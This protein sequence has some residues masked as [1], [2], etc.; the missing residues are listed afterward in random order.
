MFDIGSEVRIIAIDAQARIIAR[1]EDR[2]GV[3]YRVIYWIDGERR[4]DW[5]YGWELE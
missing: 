4:D 2:T 3:I 5:L 1:T